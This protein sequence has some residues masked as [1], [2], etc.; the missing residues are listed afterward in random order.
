MQT[1]TVRLSIDIPSNYHK[2]LKFYAIN[3]NTTI[4]DFFLDLLEKNMPQEIED[5]ILAKM[6]EDHKKDGSL[7]VAESE[8]FLKKLKKKVNLK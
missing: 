5:M 4:K 1:G 2:A 6:V 3:H 8:K 7:S